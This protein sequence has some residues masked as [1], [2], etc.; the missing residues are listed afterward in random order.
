MLNIDKRYHHS[1][2]ENSIQRY[3]LSLNKNQYQVGHPM[4]NRAKSVP[5]REKMIRHTI[6]SRVMDVI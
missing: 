4:C 6:T 2:I 1:C 5:Q 3:T